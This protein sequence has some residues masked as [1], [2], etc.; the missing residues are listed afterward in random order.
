MKTSAESLLITISNAQRASQTR[1][2]QRIKG[3]RGREEERESGLSCAEAR[4]A[5]LNEHEICTVSAGHQERQ[6]KV[7]VLNY[8]HE[9]VRA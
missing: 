1:E 4:I 3:E 5:K 8:M 2:S 9:S 6:R 7:R